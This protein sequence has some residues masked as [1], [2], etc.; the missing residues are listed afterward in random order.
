MLLFR[1]LVR[2]NHVTCT[3]RFTVD[4]QFVLDLEQ[5]LELMVLRLTDK[6]IP[7]YFIFLDREEYATWLQ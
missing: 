6:R 2:V 4:V 7:N 3:D 1:C 5:N